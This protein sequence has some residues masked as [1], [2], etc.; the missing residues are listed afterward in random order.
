M[1]ERFSMVL[2][3]GSLE[4]W[5]GL[6]RQAGFVS[7]SGEPNV[8]AWLR[9]LADSQQAW[10]DVGRQPVPDLTAHA[11]P[12]LP[13]SSGAVVGPIVAAFGA[14]EHGPMA[15]EVTAASE[16]ATAAARLPDPKPVTTRRQRAAET[17]CVH[18][19]PAGSYCRQCGKQVGT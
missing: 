15:R 9:H 5:R 8:S 4:R 13:P 3:D 6:A 7:V 16:A 17:V 10:S 11:D 12:L 18:R 14:D 1:P 19:V 2:P